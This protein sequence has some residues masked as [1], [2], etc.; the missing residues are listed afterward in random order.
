MSHIFPLKMGHWNRRTQMFARAFEC[1]VQGRIFFF[2][3][4][5]LVWL[6]LCLMELTGERYTKPP[7]FEARSLSPLTFTQLHSEKEAQT[8]GPLLWDGCPSPSVLS[9]IFGN[10]FCFLAAAGRNFSSRLRRTK[11]AL[12]LPPIP[13]RHNSFREIKLKCA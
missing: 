1:V 7:L 3:F 12:F 11:F 2:L 5:N 8:F 13:E 6:F 9:A 4:G 10:S